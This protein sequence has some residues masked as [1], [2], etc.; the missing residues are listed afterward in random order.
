MNVR[1]PEISF[2]QIM[3]DTNEVIRKNGRFWAM[4]FLVYYVPLALLQ[5]YTAGDSSEMLRLVAQGSWDAAGQLALEQENY[6]FL[7]FIV[8]LISILFF[9]FN[10]WA[11]FRMWGKEPYE[12]GDLLNRSVRKWPWVI[13]TLLLMVV[14]LIPA[15]LFLV[16]PGIF[17]TVCWS[18]A[19]YFVLF[20]DLTFIDA[21]KASYDMVIK[22]WWTIFFLFLA[23]VLVMLLVSILIVVL[24]IWTPQ[25][26]SMIAQ[27]VLSAYFNI[28]W[29]VAFLHVY[30]FTYPPAEEESFTSQIE[31]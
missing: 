2:S 15:F 26:V 19:L 12:V 29:V 20:L 5:S 24:F 14:L 18:M 17:L 31:D 16:V 11:V 9:C 7:S 3:A 28:F 4:V 21:L 10:A 27:T 6:P 25:P 1:I 30:N 13:A 22:I 23:G 8:G